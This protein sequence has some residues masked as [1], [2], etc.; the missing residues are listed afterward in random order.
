MSLDVRA[1]FA[2]PRH[3]LTSELA[4]AFA[5]CEEAWL[6]AGFITVEGIHALLSQMR[7]RPTALKTLVAG[8]ATWRA[9]D[10]FDQL[11]AAGASPDSLRVHLGHSRPTADGAKHAFYRYHPMLHSKVYLFD[12]PENQTIAF[13]GSHN[14]TGFALNGL[15]GE[16]SVRLEGPRT[17][18]TLQD[19]R[20]H[21][22][23]ASNEAVI[24]DPAQRDAYAW[25]ALQFTEGL[26]DKFNDAPR[27]G[28]S[29]RTI[30]ILAEI[31][32]APA[33][34]DTIYFELPDALGKISSLRAEI[35]IF[36]FDQLPSTP[37]QGLAQLNRASASVWC[38]TV[39]IED[40]RGGRELRADWYLEHGRPRLQRAPRPFRPQ[41]ARG[42]QQVRAQAYAE[43]RGS[44]DYLF[45]STKA[46]F[47]P[48]F[49]EEEIIEAPADRRAALNQL[50]LIPPE[51][52][53]WFRVAKLRRSVGEDDS[54]YS[55]ALRSLRPEAGSYIL[56]SPRRRERV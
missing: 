15:N 34:G 20:A 7:T 6:T 45:D 46:S 24:Y 51:D 8:A 16:A 52:K 30:V 11:L 10:A 41:P 43:V 26:R 54:A 53:P 42:M 56:M 17:D 22:M 55:I 32:G 19:I 37:G 50:D 3:E 48:V 38:R 40:D 9:M 5:A 1:L 28:E 33:K 47:E 49:D 25:W 23:A 13:V 21:V 12:L 39:G 44:F 2:T 31:A 18:P 29:K 36:L 27:D 35:H 4:T 14:L